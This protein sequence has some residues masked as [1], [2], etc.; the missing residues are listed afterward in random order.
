MSAAPARTQPF[1]DDGI[2]QDSI[3]EEQQLLAR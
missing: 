3:V 2:S 1:L